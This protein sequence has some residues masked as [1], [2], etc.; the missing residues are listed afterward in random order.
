MLIYPDHLATRQPA[1]FVATGQAASLELKELDALE[2]DGWNHWRTTNTGFNGQK[3]V[4]QPCKFGILMY[5][6]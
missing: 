4:S 1:K 6:I 5:F 3:K 2:V